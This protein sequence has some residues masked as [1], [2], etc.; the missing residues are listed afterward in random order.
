MV[1]LLKKKYN[2]LNKKKKIIKNYN[3]SSTFYDKRYKSLQEEKF[4]V[5]VNRY[6]IGGKTFLDL[7][8][9]TGLLIEHI[10]NT[11]NIQFNGRYI[12]VGVDISWNMLLQFKLKLLKMKE[13][14]SIMLILSDIENLPF[15]DNVYNLC[16]SLTSFQNLPNVHNGIVEAS[17]VCSKKSNLIISILR[18]NLYV[19]DLVD[20][21]E[22]YTEGLKVIDNQDLEDII[23]LGK[24]V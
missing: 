16:I 10:L 23:F 24:F 13:K 1:F 14:A 21:L 4:K 17:R 9:G 18:K 11:K 8:C 3:L 7:G 6:E 20:F 19:K 2:K 15:R 12:Y 22:L 5:V